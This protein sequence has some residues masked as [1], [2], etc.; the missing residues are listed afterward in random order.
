MP[1]MATHFTSSDCMV[2]DQLISYYAKRAEGEVGLIIIEGA[3][4]DNPMGRASRI[5]RP[6]SGSEKRN[7]IVSISRTEYRGV[8]LPRRINNGTGVCKLTSA[9]S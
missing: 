1:A 7:S 6:A 2:T 5:S 8:H 3:C 9:K 4:I